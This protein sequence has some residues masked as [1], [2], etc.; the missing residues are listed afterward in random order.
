MGGEPN[1]PVDGTPGKRPCRRVAGLIPPR[2]QPIG[3][4]P[5]SVWS[6]WGATTVTAGAGG[7]C[8]CPGTTDAGIGP[9]A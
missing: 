9:D 7:G 6:V 5:Q 4:P 8:S 2:R 1:G 3:A